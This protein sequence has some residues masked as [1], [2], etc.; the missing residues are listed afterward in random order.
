MI[1]MYRKVLKKM[2]NYL[3]IPQI[4]DFDNIAYSYNMFLPAEEN[5]EHDYSAIAD[6][7]AKEGV[8]MNARRITEEVDQ[9]MNRQK[10]F[11]IATALFSVVI[12]ILS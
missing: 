5:W 4:C 12:L 8:S 10:P 6:T 2:N 1:I 3:I 7:F 11:L 9:V